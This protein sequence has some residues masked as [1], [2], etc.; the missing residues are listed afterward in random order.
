LSL[1]SYTGLLSTP[2]AVWAT[3]LFTH[4]AKDAFENKIT[5]YAGL[6]N[7]VMKSILVILCNMIKLQ[8]LPPPMACTS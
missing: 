5:T 8:T 1:S 2:A 4:Q 6:I 7:A 3:C